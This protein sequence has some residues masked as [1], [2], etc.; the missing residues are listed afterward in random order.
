MRRR[1]F[2]FLFCLA[3]AA[4]LP[5][6]AGQYRTPV[7]PVKN[8]ILMI[9]DGT[10]MGIVSAA[11]WYQIYNK[12]GEE[13]LAI[14]PWLCGTV[15]T[16]CS[17]APIGDSAPT[18]SCYMTG[19]PQQ[20]GNVSIYPEAS[21]G[22]DLTPVDASRAYQPLVTILEAVKHEQGKSTGLVVT[23]EFPHAT[24]A[25]CAA[26]YDDRSAYDCIAPQMA[27]QGLDV[28]FGGGVSILTDDIRSRFKADGT[29]LMTDDAAAFR[30][31]KG[32]GKL[33]ALFCPKTLPFD[34]DRDDST[35]PSLAEMTEKALERLS[36]NEQGFFL[37][38]EG[39]KIDFAAH[40]NDAAAC[41]TEYLAFDNA[42]RV[43]L[44][45][46]RKDGNTAVVVLPDHGNSGFTIGNRKL[47]SGYARK[48]LEEL[49]GN[50]SQYKMTAKGLERLLLRT[51][52]GDVPAVVETQTGI[53]L[54][55]KELE[56]LLSSGNYTSSGNAQKGNPRLDANLVK[57]MNSRTFF[58]FTTGGHTGEDVFLAVY[59]PQGDV[60]MGMNTNEEINHYLFDAAGLKMSLE[61]MTAKVFAKHGDVFDGMECSI[62]EKGRHAVLTVKNGP[63]TLVV[64]AFG[65]VVQMNGEPVRLKTVVVYIGKNK[66]FYLPA[67]LREL[68]GQHPS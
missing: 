18:T 41:I 60:P 28:M 19:M 55:D 37:M 36:R 2:L 21:L 59:H 48:S 57:L 24:P 31:E 15:K 52:A 8:I 62:E 23:C 35:V 12:T 26:H 5:V 6:G 32:E 58:G 50:V 53:K 29:K 44:D 40:D 1:N 67:S 39:S 10:S 42:V 43:A 46:A 33:W 63:N 54:T 4:V 56:T 51:A 65:S 49:F 14:D 30:N 47:S 64:P 22:R 7:R 11:R 25:D 13:R 17:N 34:L 68:M 16:C 9:P 27:A 38:V 20:A 3:V 61:D 45:F 66:T